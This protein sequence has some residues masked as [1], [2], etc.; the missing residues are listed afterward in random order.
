[1]LGTVLGSASGDQY[2]DLGLL[3]WPSASIATK[4]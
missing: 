2:S 1:V 3:D 4:S